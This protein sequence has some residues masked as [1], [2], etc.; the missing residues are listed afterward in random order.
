LTTYIYVEKRTT[1]MIE[2][3]YFSQSFHHNDYEIVAEA[4]PSILLHLR[5]PRWVV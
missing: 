5:I 2:F 1:T 4:G 3:N